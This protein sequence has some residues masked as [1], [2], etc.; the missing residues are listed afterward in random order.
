MKKNY[1][2]D[3][4]VLLHD[5]QAIFRFEDN[6]VIIPIYVIEEV[7]QFKR[8][9]TERGRNAR[10]IARLLDGLRGRGSLASGVP[11]DTGGSLKIAIPAQRPQLATA[12]DHSAQ[13]QAI[14]P[15]A[16]PLPASTA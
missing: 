12:L 9:S 1:V 16:L 4:N 11:L 5:P 2:L 14:L 8:E 15:P 13:D 10:S 6:S 3:T 7:D